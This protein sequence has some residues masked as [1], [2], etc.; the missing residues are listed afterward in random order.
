MKKILKLIFVLLLIFYTNINILNANQFTKIIEQYIFCGK[1][2][3]NKAESSNPEDI[4]FEFIDAINNNEYLVAY[5]LT[6]NSQ[7]SNFNSFKT[8]FY[9]KVLEAEIYEY[10]ISENNNNK[11]IIYTEIYYF[12]PDKNS[13]ILIQDFYL[14]FINKEWKITNIKTTETFDELTYYFGE[15]Q[16]DDSKKYAI[17]NINKKIDEIKKIKS[18]L[19][20]EVL[21]K[22]E[23]TEIEENNEEEMEDERPLYT[24]VKTVY[25][26]ENGEVKIIELEENYQNFHFNFSLVKYTKAYFDNNN[27]IFYQSETIRSITLNSDDEEI[28]ENLREINGMKSNEDVFLETS[29]IINE[30]PIIQLHI[31]YTYDGDYVQTIFIPNADKIIIYQKNNE[32]DY[33]LLGNNN[34]KFVGFFVDLKV[35]DWH[36]NIE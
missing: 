2:L 35:A 20:I 19:S 29:Y 26:D 24:E 12:S 14:Q 5:K 15:I 16:L 8:S 27:L 6:S 4:V 33:E 31:D 1:F 13:E 3:F 7:W 32:T 36:D 23:L 34:L 10:D 30:T 17:S 9:G 11:A 22:S 25:R 21:D 18:E 28:L